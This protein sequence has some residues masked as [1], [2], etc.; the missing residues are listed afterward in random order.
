MANK[1]NA[2]KAIRVIARR[3]DVS[4]NRRSRMRS[5]LRKVRGEACDRFGTVLG[6][7]YNRDHADHF[8]LDLK[9]RRNV[10][11]H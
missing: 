6:P 8:H 1:T 11:C 7:G 10:A 3:T 2:K 5:F 9:E 4:K